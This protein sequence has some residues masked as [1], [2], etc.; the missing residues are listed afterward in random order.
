MS[1]KIMS[2]GLPEGFKADQGKDRYDL[3]GEL[4]EREWVRVLTFGANKYTRKDKKG[5]ILVDGADNWRKVEQ[6]KKRY[7][8]ALRR[9]LKEYRLGHMTDPES[10]LHVLGHAMC[11]LGFLLELELEEIE[12]RHTAGH[13]RLGDVSG[14]V[15]RRLRRSGGRKRTRGSK[16]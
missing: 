14:P 15:P 2:D 6:P 1:R 16:Q 12:A 13:E 10:R 9:H 7:F 5:R 4:A 8:S 3:V 11:D